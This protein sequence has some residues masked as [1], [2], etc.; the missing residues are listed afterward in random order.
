M[1]LRDTYQIARIVINPNN[2]DIVYVAAIGYLWGYIGDR[3]LFKTTDGGETWTKLT[4]GLPSDGKTGAID[5]V[6][7]STDPNTRYVAFY[8][9]LRKP[10]RFDSGGPNGGIFKTIDGGASWKQLTN[11][12]PTGDTGRIGLRFTGETPRLLWRSV[13]MDF[14]LKCTKKTITI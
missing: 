14:S 2:P 13:N 6:M 11:G 5:L 9:R 4:K 10:Y 7:D 8:Q 12:L 1:G 3:G